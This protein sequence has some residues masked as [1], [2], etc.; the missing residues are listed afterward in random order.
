[1]SDIIIRHK[2]MHNN[3]EWVRVLLGYNLLLVQRS[4]DVVICS[5]TRMHIN[6]FLHDYFPAAKPYAPGEI[7]NAQ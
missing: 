7:G 3:L 2:F 1:M 6:D 4:Q 5:G